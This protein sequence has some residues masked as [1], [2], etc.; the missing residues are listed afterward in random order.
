MASNI[1]IMSCTK[2]VD[3]RY[4]DVNEFVEGVE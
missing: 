2:H 3:I 1:S 4:K